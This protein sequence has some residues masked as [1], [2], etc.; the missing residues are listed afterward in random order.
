MLGYHALHELKSYSSP[1][2]SVTPHRG[3]MRYHT[4]LLQPHSDAT[5]SLWHGDVEGY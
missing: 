1:G 4:P 2:V 3:T 5:P